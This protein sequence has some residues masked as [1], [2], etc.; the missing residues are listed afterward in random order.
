MKI[1]EIEGQKELTGTIRVSGA[2]NATVALI[3]AAILTDE[4][5][6]ICN[7]PEITDT[8]ALCDI[9]EELNVTTKRASESIIIDPTDMVNKEISEEHSRKLRA[10]YYFMGALLGKYKRAEMHFPGGC[11]IGARPIDLHLKGFEALGAKVTND[12]NKYI[13]EAEELKGANIYLDFASVGATINI[14]LAAVKATG[15]TI[16]DNAAKEPEIVNIAT[17]L[18]NMG[19]RITGAGT[20]TIKI[21]GVEELHSCFHEVI[22]DRI[23]AGSYI[24]MGA[25]CGKKLKIDNIIPEH[26]DSLIS[27]L[28]E[29]GVELNI[30]RDYMEVSKPEKYNATN[31]KTAVYPG[32]PTDLQQP[33]T[34]LL[35]QSEGKSKVLET[36]W[37]NRFM[38]VPYLNNLG[39]D[40]TVKNQT[41]TI[42]GPRQLKGRTV[43]ATD[44][45]AGA[46]MVA[47][48]LAAKGKTTI[49]NVEHIL[50]GY[51]QIVEKLNNVGAKLTLK[52]I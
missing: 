40:I 31:I 18:N 29:M 34:V 23:E 21:K 39:A 10:S 30:G 38:H 26:L 22:P 49:T 7:V 9:L 45:R 46:A 15:T 33:F 19:A 4:T 5:A 50:R 41:A 51:E 42:I 1:I 17:F 11:S 13:V 12:K 32:F 28:E 36:I 35:T 52:E 14:M 6:T 2:K 37:E 20:S 25:L 16:I 24:I 8:D 48:G 3:P 27:K 44:L 47:A 43:V